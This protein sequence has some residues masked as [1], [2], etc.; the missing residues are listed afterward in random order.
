MIW[1]T[2]DFHFGQRN[3]T[4]K[5]LSSW[6]SG[7]RDFDSIAEMDNTIIKTVNKYVKAD[8]IL[9]Y[10]GDWSFRAGGRDTRSYRSSL[11]CRIIHY[12]LGNHDKGLDVTCFN[13]VQDIIKLP[14][15][16]IH[17]FMSHYAHRVWPAHHKG[18]IHLYG[19]SHGSIQDHGRSMD[20][21]IDV[22]HKM[23]G[24]Y[25]PFSVDDIMSIMN[26]KEVI[27][28]DHHKKR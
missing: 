11:Q 18:S 14:Y 7:Y 22:A 19:H 2:S 15:P 20:V 25:R 24:E 5:K 17:I 4:G 27:E 3:I 21:G 28:L 16:P 8:D 26:K 1:F 10:L 12:A 23:F 13:T 6:V 9:Y